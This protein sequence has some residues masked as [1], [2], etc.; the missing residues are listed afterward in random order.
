MFVFMKLVKPDSEGKRA[1][2]WGEIRDEGTTGPQKHI[3]TV[4]D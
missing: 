4:T 3:R 1:G 2:R